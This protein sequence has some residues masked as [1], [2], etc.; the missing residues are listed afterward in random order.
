L[1]D[2]PC[3]PHEIGAAFFSLGGLLHAPATHDPM[4]RDF[5]LYVADYAA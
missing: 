3:A 5:L 2:D 1:P 4:K